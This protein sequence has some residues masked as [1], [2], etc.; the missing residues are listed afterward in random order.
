M[1]AVMFV[2]S[3]VRMR[4]IKMWL[5][6][7]SQSLCLYFLSLASQHVFAAMTPNDWKNDAIWFQGHIDD[8]L[9]RSGRTIVKLPEEGRD[10]RP[11]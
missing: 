7:K 4:A 11:F 8:W 6:T 2:C 5:A 1:N 10:P 9:D 3:L